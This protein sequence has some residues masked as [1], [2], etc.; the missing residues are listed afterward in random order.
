MERTEV[1]D[2]MGSLMPALRLR[3]L[4]IKIRRNDQSKKLPNQRRAGFLQF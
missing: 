3:P 2:V 1:L 4:L